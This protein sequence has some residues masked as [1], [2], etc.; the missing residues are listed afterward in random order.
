[1]DAGR[2]ATVDGW[3][4]ALRAPEL[5]ADPAA[6][7]TAA[8]MALVRGDEASLNGLLVALAD[9]ADAGP[10]PDGTRSV[11]AAVALIQGMGGYGGP[12]S[13]GQRRAAGHQTRDQSPLALVRSSPTWILGHPAVRVR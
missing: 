13:D 6:L 8:W 12:L 5:E 1:M 10:L 2:A 11:E 7:V 9:V 3:L 4:R